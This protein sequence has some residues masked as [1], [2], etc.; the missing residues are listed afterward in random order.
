MQNKEVEEAKSKLLDLATAAHN[1]D[2]SLQNLAKASRS[3]K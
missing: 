1:A 2:I 3:K